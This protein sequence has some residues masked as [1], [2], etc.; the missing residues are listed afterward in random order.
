M[1]P[2]EDDLLVSHSATSGNQT[3]YSLALEWTA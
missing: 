2:E 3:S 1:P